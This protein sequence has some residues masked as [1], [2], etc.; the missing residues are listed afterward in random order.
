MDPGLRTPLL[1]FFRRGEVDRDIRMQAARGALA[2][3]AHE[4]LALLILLA[5]DP[6][7]EIA[8]A[9]EATLTAIPLPSLQSF[10]A[11][12]DVSTEMRAC[13]AAR[14]V[15]PGG[16]PALDADAPIVDLG[17]EPET[18]AP[19]AAPAMVADSEAAGSAESTADESTDEEAERKR[20]ASVTQKIA[21]LSVAQRM[22]LAMKGSREE[23]SLLIRDPNKLVSTA[24]L[25]SPKIT[26][27]EI[28]SMAKMANVSEEIL[29]IIATNR[30]WVKN[31]NV[32]LALVR[33]PK[34]P[35]AVAMNLMSRLNDKDL[36]QLSTNRNV[37]E[38]L[39]VTARKKIVIDK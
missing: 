26:E 2:P 12:S 32:M 8:A 1:D 25:S 17:P 21:S 34:S 38:I 36:R 11:R 4:Q 19:D 3:R 13:F 14:G 28:E 23:R 29:R 35:V 39:R 7:P 15:E 30:A 20:K 31:Y 5:A 9:A 10:L 22:N 33:N 24:V 18:V 37:A 6:D 16:T 27:S